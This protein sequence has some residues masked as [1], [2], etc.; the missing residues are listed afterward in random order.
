MVVEFECRTRLPVGMQEAFDRSRSIDLH[1][2]SMVRSR[3]RAVAGVTTGLIG[4]GQHVTLRA[5][6]FGVPIRM[7]SRITRMSPP[8]SFT[9]EQVRGPFRRFRHDHS[10]IADG[11]G[12]L[13][14]DHVVLQ[15]AAR[16]PGSNRRARGR[17]L[18]APPHRTAQCAPARGIR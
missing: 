1:M 12:M 16:H 2:S 17:A 6:H 5:W 9:D 14:V 7:A 11:E 15:G 18:S 13:M 3:E 8:D 4:E 10:F